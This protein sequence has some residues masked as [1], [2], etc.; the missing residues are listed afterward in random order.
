VTV[1]D[2]ERAGSVQKWIADGS[3]G[4]RRSA[5]CKRCARECVGVGLHNENRDE[6]CPETQYARRKENQLENCFG[7]VA[8]CTQ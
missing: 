6:W 3:L 1:V 2:G 8:I 5:G 4:A 7:L